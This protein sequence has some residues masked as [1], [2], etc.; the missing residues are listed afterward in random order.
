MNDEIDKNELPDK[1]IYD[2]S[3]GT[4]NFGPLNTLLSDFENPEK[5][6]NDYTSTAK[7]NSI[8]RK[9][10]AHY[11]INND[12]DS[13]NAKRVFSSMSSGAYGVIMH[14]FKKQMSS[15]IYFIDFLHQIDP[16]SKY[17]RTVSEIIENGLLPEKQV[18]LKLI[19]E[20]SDSLNTGGHF[21]C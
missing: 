15:F 18:D 14:S 16:E 1:I 3:L 13:E 5:G 12:N 17:C 19:Q 6:I 20:Q 11:Q 2:T 8:K 4:A 21:I 7:V 9:W 10:L